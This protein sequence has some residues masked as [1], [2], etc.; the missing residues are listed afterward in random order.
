MAT[1]TLRRLGAGSRSTPAVGVVIASALL[2]LLT[3]AVFPDLFVQNLIGGVAYGM[4]L[5]IIALGLALILGLLGVVNFAHGGLFMLGAYGAYEIVVTQGLSFWAALVVVPIAVGV[6][7]VAMEVSVLRRLYGKNPVIGLLATFGVFLMIEEAT[8]ARWGGTPLTF[9]IPPALQGAIPLGVGQIATIRLLTVVVAAFIIVSIYSLMYRTDFGLTIRAGLQDR[10]M[11]E[12][13][14][15]NIPMRFTIVFFLG[16]AIAGLAGVLRGAETG[17]DL[18][19]GFEFVLLAFV[20]VIIGGVGSIFGSVVSGLLVGV[21]VFILPV[22]AR[23]LASVTGVD[24]LN[25]A[26][27]GGVVPYIVMLVVLLVRPRGLFGEEGLLE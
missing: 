14:G 22:T 21:S 11:A 26:G 17:M 2:F 10:E 27:I 19:L 18:S 23:A 16:S 8:R 13:I 4:V 7:G 1:S 12:F 24:A 20:I 15:I 6:L 5:A 9:E 3:F 25:V